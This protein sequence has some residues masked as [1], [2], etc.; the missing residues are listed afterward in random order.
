MAEAGEGPVAGVLGLPVACYSYSQC[1]LGGP[2]L[3]PWA[4]LFIFPPQC[5]SFLC[6]KG[7]WSVLPPLQLTLLV[8][9]LVTSLSLAVPRGE[10]RN[11]EDFQ[12]P[13]VC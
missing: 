2:G 1:A 13:L 8:L 4:P 5:C 10:L 11:S 9:I 7:L 6:G 3:L 12:T